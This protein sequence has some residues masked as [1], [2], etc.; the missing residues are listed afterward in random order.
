MRN[1]YGRTPFGQSVLLARRLI[2]AGD[3][4]IAAQE[5][6]AAAAE[7]GAPGAPES[8]DAGVPAADAQPV[9]ERG[10]PVAGEEL[11]GLPHTVGG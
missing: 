2:E 3:R 6:A 4:L 9:K 1:R 5:A 7:P 8:V 11:E 10:E